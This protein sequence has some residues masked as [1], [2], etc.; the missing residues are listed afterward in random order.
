M[1]KVEPDHDYSDGSA[2]WR[3]EQFDKGYNRIA[4]GYLFG[5]RHQDKPLLCLAAR[6]AMELWD[7]QPSLID[8]PA[9]YEALSIEVTYGETL[10]AAMAVTSD[11]RRCRYSGWSLND[12]M[13][14]RMESGV[15]PRLRR[16]EQWTASVL[17]KVVLTADPDVGAQVQRPV[18][19]LPSCWS[20]GV[21]PSSA[22]A[23][24]K[25]KLLDFWGGPRVE[26]NFEH[27]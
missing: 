10:I 7:L 27:P 3:V 11:D 4:A 20:R 13:T 21:L 22:A 12:S 16:I 17:N 6:A 23:R 9:D 18:R 2:D 15:G 5:H 25:F 24:Q 1:L 14:M 19:S 26:W 8:P